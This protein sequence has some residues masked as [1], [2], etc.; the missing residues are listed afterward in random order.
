HSVRNLYEHKYRIAN[1]F[2]P[3]N[4]CSNSLKKIEAGMQDQEMWL[5]WPETKPNLSEKNVHV[6]RA[7]LVQP[8]TVLSECRAMLSGDEKARADR[9]KFDKH[10]RRYT[11]AR[12]ALRDILGRYLEID[13]AQVVFE[14]EA[15]GKPKLAENQNSAG[16]VFNVSHSEEMAVYA[17]TCGRAVGI[18]VEFVQ[19][20]ISD[21]DKIAKRFFS[22]MESEAYLR[23]PHA[24]KQEAFFNC[25]T[26]KEAFIKAIGEGL[27]HPLHR[28]DVSFIPGT[29]PAL[30]ATRPDA[31]EVANWSL[32]AFTPAENYVG[33]LVVKGKYLKL[34][35]WQ[36]EGIS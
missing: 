5:N 18:D 25:W 15:H 9:F 1:Y 10:R 36:W 23:L 20:K 12:G 21:A 13:A 27:T 29:T 6:W 8:D 22:Q 28:F 4:Q 2:N 3:L 11:I 7:S 33:A 32:S 30:L 17:I 31:S 26:R 14:Y 19:R 16:I 24:Q 35:C 34:K